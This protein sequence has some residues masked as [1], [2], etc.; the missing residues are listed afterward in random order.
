MD[1]GSGKLKEADKGLNEQGK[2][3]V[4]RMNKLGMLVDL[5]HVGEKPSGT[6]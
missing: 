5:S 1:E 3:I 4:R 2:Q 6:L